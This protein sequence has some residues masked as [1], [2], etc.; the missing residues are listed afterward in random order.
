MGHIE[1]DGWSAVYGAASEDLACDLMLRP[2]TIPDG[3]EARVRE[4]RE[5]DPPSPVTHLIEIRRTHGR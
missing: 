5:D 3:F 4:R 2:G 1:P